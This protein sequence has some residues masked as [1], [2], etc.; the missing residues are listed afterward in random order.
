MQAFRRSKKF[1]TTTHFFCLHDIDLQDYTDPTYSLAITNTMM[2][3]GHFEA[4]RIEGRTNPELIEIPEIFGRKLELA[5]SLRE[6]KVSAEFRE[7]FAGACS[8]MD[9][10]AAKAAAS[11][12][13]A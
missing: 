10:I 12:E 4:P 7:I 9:E 6:G 5:E 8:F 11:P 3:E 2:G 1:F 13:T